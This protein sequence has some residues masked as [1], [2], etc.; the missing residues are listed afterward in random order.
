MNNIISSNPDTW[1]DIIRNKYGIILDEHFWENN[2]LL[3]A[4]SGIMAP[5][6]YG[7]VRGKSGKGIDIH[8]AILKVASKKGF[9]L[10]GNKYIRPGNPLESQLN[11]FLKLV[12][13]WK[14]M[15]NLP[16]E[17][18]LLVCNMMLTIVSVQTNQKRNK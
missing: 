11:T 3:T 14:S 15:N 5:V 13:Y 1:P 7:R 12:R 8:K 18:M 17:Q 6:I 4:G 2:P 9:V 16:A 10:P